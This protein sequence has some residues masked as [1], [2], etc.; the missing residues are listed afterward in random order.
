ME[1]YVPATE[2]LVTEIIVQDISRSVD[3]YVSLGFHSFRK[4]GDFA[5]LLWEGH[6]LFL[7]ERSA[8]S[9]IA[10]TAWGDPPSFPLANIRVMVPN[11][12]TYWAR[13]REMGTRIVQSIGNRAYG[14]RDFTLSDPDGFGVRFA[15]LLDA[16]LNREVRAPVA[17]SRRKR[18][19]NHA[20]G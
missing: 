7:V 17:S 16:V 18:S 6:R 9:N 4:E 13:A 2:Q 11:V 3:F 15:S 5:E 12:D 19:R 14:L 10:P 8:F 20:Q 1:T